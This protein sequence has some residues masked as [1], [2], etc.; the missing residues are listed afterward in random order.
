M[1]QLRRE[2]DRNGHSHLWNDGCALLERGSLC[3]VQSQQSLCAGK[4]PDSSGS[5]ASAQRGWSRR[6]G[7]GLGW[8]GLPVPL[9]GWDRAAVCATARAGTQQPLLSCCGSGT[10]PSSLA[11]CFGVPGRTNGGD[12]SCE[13]GWQSSSGWAE[14]G[15]VLSVAV[16]GYSAVAELWWIT[17]PD[18]SEA[19]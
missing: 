6:A 9:A 14:P 2:E 1:I 19:P 3:S 15:L 13:R 4:A 8:A 12:G 16:C 7:A 11:P 18:T 17:N 10:L 5:G